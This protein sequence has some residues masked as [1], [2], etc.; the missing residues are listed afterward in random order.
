LTFFGVPANS[1]LVF[2]VWCFFLLNVYPIFLARQSLH[3]LYRRGNRHF[4]FN[5]FTKV[6]DWTNETSVGYFWKPFGRSLLV[7]TL[8]CIF[9][10]IF[11][12][13]TAY[14]GSDQYEAE[15][16]HCGDLYLPLHHAAM[17]SRLVLEK[18]IY[19]DGLHF[20]HVG[21]FQAL[22]GWAA[23]EWFVYGPFPIA[24][25]LGLHYAPFAY[26]LFGGVLQNM[27]SNL[28]EAAT[29][30]G[31][32]EMEE[33]H[34]GYDSDAETRLALDHSL[35]FLSAMSS[36]SVAVTL[37]N[38]V[39]YYV[40][41]TR[42]QTMLA[43]SG[44]NSGQGYVMAIVLILIGLIILTLNQIQTG[45]RKQFTTVSG[46]SGQIT[47]NNLG[48]ALANGC[49]AFSS[50]SWSSSSASDRWCPSSLN[51]C[52]LTLAIILQVSLGGL[53]FPKNP[54]R[55]TT[56]WASSTKRRFGAL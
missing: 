24:L 5:N 2:L 56:S 32:S 8:A 31:H 30:L 50:P 53:G 28:E 15:A 39:D 4:T 45:S 26:I 37:G 41:A 22:F 13:V 10:V 16:F 17:D 25:I 9:A 3:D 48:K 21:E 6:F 38:P 40:L 20:G 29:I 52:C 33:F 18:L 34:Q 42:M 11:G 44:R 12:G 19:L 36:Y 43:G 46:K 54:Y 49:G 55:P 35:G 27:D 1:I 47:K 7:S 51:H 23:P 14:F